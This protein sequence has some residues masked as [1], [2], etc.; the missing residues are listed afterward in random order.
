MSSSTVCMSIGVVTHSMVK[1]ISIVNEAMENLN[2]GLVYRG[3]LV[4]SELIST[5]N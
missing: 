1:D 2:M 5:I 4:T 3:N